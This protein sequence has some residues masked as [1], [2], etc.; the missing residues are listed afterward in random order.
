[1]QINKGFHTLFLSLISFLATAGASNP[2]SQAWVSNNFVAKSTP[3]NWS[4]LCKSGQSLLGSNGCSPD[5]NS[6]AMS[7]TCNQL[8]DASQ[9]E[10]LSYISP[11]HN[12][13]G[14]FVFQ[15]NP[16]Q[17]TTGASLNMVVDATL[18][19]NSG[20]MCEPLYADGTPATLWNT[21]PSIG[22]VSNTIAID[23]F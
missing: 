16:V 10:K 23:P 5:C 17:A 13:N 20:Y 8:Y 3:I 12:S 18:A 9:I 7:S 22:T 2:A 4:Q 15:L 14:V 21:N 19:S 1:M 11:P 6:S